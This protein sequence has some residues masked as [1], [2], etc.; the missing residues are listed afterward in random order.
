MWNYCFCSKKIIKFT[1]AMLHYKCRNVTKFGRKATDNIKT[2]FSLQESISY[3]VF[4]FNKK[5]L[6]HSCFS[7]NLPKC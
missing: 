2:R 4:N 5:R 7:V 3:Q 1:G 6:R